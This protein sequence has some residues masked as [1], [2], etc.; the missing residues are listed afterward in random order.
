MPGRAARL[1]IFTQK[2]LV[3]DELCA[4]NVLRV[5]TSNVKRDSE[6]NEPASLS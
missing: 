5:I 6:W 2:R 3:R 4:A 1:L